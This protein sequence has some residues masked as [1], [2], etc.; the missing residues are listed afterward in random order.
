MLSA[1]RH[2]RLR[3]NDG[4]MDFFD[5]ISDNNAIGEGKRLPMICKIE[6]KLKSKNFGLFRDN[7]WSTY[8][9]F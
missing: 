1:S 3:G 8:G 2:S 9:S 4:A 5:T 7:Y 6:K